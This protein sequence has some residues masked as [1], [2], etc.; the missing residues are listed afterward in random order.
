MGAR[1]RLIACVV[2]AVVVVVAVWVLL[3]SPERNK[4]ASL[5]TQIAAARSTLAAEQ[6]QVASAE[7]ART[8]YPKEVRAVTLLEKAVPLTDQEPQ[9]IDLIN[10]LEVGHLIHWTVTDLTQAGP[11]SSGF[12]TINLSFTFSLNFFR[13]QSFFTA[14]DALTATD[15]TNVRVKGRLF[16]INAVTLGGSQATVA[17]TAYQSP[18][19]ATGAAGTTTAAAP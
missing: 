1:E 12:P 6:A 8:D 7:Q 17:M 18:L 5:N 10:A 11:T 2:A 19:G 13:L 16:T 9:L 3:V 15:G 4:A 14:L